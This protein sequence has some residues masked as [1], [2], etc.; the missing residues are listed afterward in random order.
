MRRTG[1]FVAVEKVTLISQPVTFNTRADRDTI[2][3]IVIDCRK[4]EFK[5]RD[6]LCRQSN[7]DKREPR[8]T[9]KMC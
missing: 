8:R 3:R 4:F 7:E 9:H 2:I 6:K 1:N 5:G